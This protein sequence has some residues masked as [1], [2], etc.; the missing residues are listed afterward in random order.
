MNTDQLKN[1][2]FFDL[3]NLDS[4]RKEALQGAGDKNASDQALEK[5]AKQ[6]ES[7]FTQMLLKSMRKANEA[8]EDKDSPFNSSGVKFFEEMHDQQ[9]AMHLSDKGS[10]GLADLIVQQLSPSTEGFKPA[11]VLRGDTALPARSETKTNT[12]VKPSAEDSMV[13]TSQTAN[14][15]AASFSSPDEFVEKVWDY[16]KSA[17]KKLGLNPAVMVAQAALETGWGQHIINKKEGGSSHNLF[18]IKADSRWQGDSAKKSTLEFEQGLPVR[19]QAD[20]R[21]YDSIAD[22]FDDYVSFL[23][24]NPRYEQALQKADDSHAYL[25]ELQAAGYATDP[26]YADKIKSVLQ[27]IDVSGLVSGAFTKGVR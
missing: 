25:D 18:N 22:S 8:L 3:G 5:A 11:S 10:L 7:I 24:G 6:F 14:E 15:Q 4:I 16:A 12:T 17:A 1:Q 23:K 2:S 20:F 26:N 27:R 9:L 21:A 13:V 19:K